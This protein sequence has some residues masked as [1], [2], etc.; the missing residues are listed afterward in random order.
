M[1]SFRS[2]SW[3]LVTF[4]LAAVPGCTCATEREG[5]R[6]RPLPQ[7]HGGEARPALPYPVDEPAPPREAFVLITGAEA[8][9]ALAGASRAGSW[10]GMRRGGEERRS[11]G[12]FVCR[13]EALYGRAPILLPDRVA[14]VLRDEERGLVLTAVADSRGPWI[15]VSRA[16]AV[17]PSAETRAA[18]VAIE[19][20]RLL[21]VTT[22][23]TCHY[24]VA[25]TEVGV[26]D[27]EWY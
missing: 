6:A 9:L 13:L 19:L 2:P 7:A 3:V 25:G 26:R 18:N 8:P 16:A 14:W 17:D 27:G 23:T 22:P 24:T 21:D 10:A 1:L 15:G 4:V 5:P 20:A 11:A 12:N